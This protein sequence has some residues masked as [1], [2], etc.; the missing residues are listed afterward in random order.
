MNLPIISIEK[1]LPSMIVGLCVVALSACGSGGGPAP[2]D[3][4]PV[5]L[6]LLAGHGL[7]EGPITVA[8]GAAEEH[9][10]VVISCPAG[11]EAC[12]LNLAADGSAS[13]QGSGGIPSIMPALVSWR[14]AAGD[15]RMAAGLN[16]LP[17]F[18]RDNVASRLALTATR[19]VVSSTASTTDV[20]PIT[21][22]T[23]NTGVTQATANADPNSP[24]DNRAINAGY[25]RGNLVFERI[26]FGLGLRQDTRVEPRPPSY[27]RVIPPTSDAPQWKGVEHLFASLSGEKYY[28]VYHSDI[29]SNADADYLALGYWAWAPGPNIDRRP[30]VGAAASGNDPFH[31]GHIAAVEGRATYEGAATGLYAGGDVS[32]PFR[33]FDAGV[34]LTADFD[35]NRIEGLVTDGRDSANDK[36]LFQVLTLETA[37]I[38]DA[39]T[40]FFSGAVSGVLDGR[41]AEGNWGGQFYGNGLASTDIPVS[42]AEAPGSVAGT[43]GARVAGG[44]SLLGVFGAYKE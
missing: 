26:N 16:G 29:E 13:Y 4:S 6:Q 31:A 28:S 14:V 40:A 7:T 5:S 19:S 9:G 30:F 24:D 41:S 37:A 38:Q 22:G 17:E 32:L 11:G 39:D 27:R 15:G 34:K 43:F 18:A 1:C 20:A 44:D 10:N 2:K 42:F 36:L 3:P 8:P 33:S 12:V 23:W 21:G 25:L 35:E